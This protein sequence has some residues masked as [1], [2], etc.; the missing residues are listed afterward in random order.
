MPTQSFA[1]LTLVIGLALAACGGGDDGPDAFPTTDPTVK[2]ERTAAAAEEAT[3]RRSPTRRRSTR[4]GGQR[5]V[6]W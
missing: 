5:S 2:A 6:R 3:T 1:V 4:S